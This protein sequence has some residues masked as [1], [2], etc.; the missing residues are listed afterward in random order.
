MMGFSDI[1]ENG[2]ITTSNN[3]EHITHGIYI[4]RLQN[5]GSYYNTFSVKENSNIQS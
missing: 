1:D 2:D 4:T 3:F 5:G